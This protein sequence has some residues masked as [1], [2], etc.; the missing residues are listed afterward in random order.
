V[1]PRTRHWRAELALA[2]VTAIW[3]F[4]FVTVKQALD[5]ITPV[6]FLALRFSLATLA[7][8]VLFRRHRPRRSGW[9]AGMLAGALLF[10]SYLFQT[11]GLKFTTPAKS[12]FVT[13]LAVP[14]VPFLASL[15][16]RSRPR[17][18]EVFGAAMATAGL[19]LMTL[20]LD[21]WEVNRGDALTL[22][23]ALG[24]AAHIVAVGH[25][26]PRVSFESLAVAQVAVAT[27]LSLGTFWWVETPSINWSFGLYVA[28]VVT[29]LFA[30]A[31]AFTV[32]A[33]A[34]Q[35]T[36]ATRAAIIFALEPVIAWAA[37]F[38]L[39]GETLS[40]RGV[41]GAA[42]IL[43]GIVLVEMKPTRAQQHPSH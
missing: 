29:G 8:A 5:D 7:L 39:T 27:F 1:T 43:A 24:F 41:A 9:V 17:A 15:V 25:L 14:A 18:V 28:V 36:T 23:C 13:G 33:W 42:L 6:L 30:T 21:T 31:L 22:F 37:A 12:A 20:R 16:Y 40:L 3:G 4:T 32:Q 35:Y 26:A 10:I 19:G 2:G 34:Q 11:V 38:A